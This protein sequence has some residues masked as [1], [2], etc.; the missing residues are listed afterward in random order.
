MSCATQSQPQ[1]L[2]KIPKLSQ[3]TSFCIKTEVKALKGSNKMAHEY[4]LAMIDSH[5]CTHTIETHPGFTFI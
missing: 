4:K 5:I 3:K 1:D 2:L